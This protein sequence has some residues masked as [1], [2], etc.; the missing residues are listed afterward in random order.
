VRLRSPREYWFRG[1]QL[2][3]NAV[4]WALPKARQNGQFRFLERYREIILTVL[5]SI[6]T[7]EL[8]EL[9]DAILLHRFPIFAGI[10]ETGTDLDWRRD[11]VSGRSSQLQY[12]RFVPYLDYERVGDHKVVWELN[13][14][15]HWIVLARAFLVFR[16]ERYLQEI[17]T[18]M[19]SWRAQN[20]FLQGINWASTLEVSLRS[21]SWL[22]VVA[23]L[24]DHFTA[25]EQ[26]RWWADLHQNGR[27][28][29]NNLSVYFAPNTHLLGEALALAALGRV[30][31][32][33]RWSESGDATLFQQ[34][35]AQVLPDGGYFEQ[36]TF[37]HVYALDMFLLHYLLRGD[38]E[39]D[40]LVTD[41]AHWLACI[42]GPARKL[43]FLGDDDG[44]N[45]LWPYRAR[46]DFGRIALE[47]AELVCKRK[48]ECAPSSLFSSTGLATF[49]K[50]DL[51]ILIDCGPFGAGGA[52]HSHSDVLSFVVRR[53]DEEILI[54]P[55]TYTY[56]ADLQAR[57]L[58]RSTE[59]HSTV[60]VDQADQ[61]RKVNPFRWEDKPTVDVL[62]WR[63]NQLL[64]AECRTTHFTHRREFRF[65]GNLT[66]IDTV[67]GAAG[68]HD[69]EQFWQTGP[70]PVLQADGSLT[71][72]SAVLTLP[73]AATVDVVPSE[74]STCY[75]EKT[76]SYRVRARMSCALPVRLESTLTFHKS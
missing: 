31:G 20:P 34:R 67:K 40:S 5:P 68:Q 54:D 45:L 27:Y 18:E 2:I 76:R 14:H 49:S 56:T 63:P 9:A 64:I 22:A 50:D 16:D 65:D 35:S 44:G 66:V 6:V 41:M 17:R 23:L 75:G 52:G 12:F 58:F 19:S 55:G 8:L 39:P 13:R 62:E 73:A 70:Q 10:V 38:E 61:G 3:A 74:R 53:G 30:L 32:I 21:L 15:Q 4:M 29:A 59:S 7:S 60:R 71:I 36:S 46:E 25:E 43:A 28:I 72:G 69:V 26:R 1:T 24:G 47:R 42:L 48:F 37:Y 51:F 57:D 33:P 11:Y